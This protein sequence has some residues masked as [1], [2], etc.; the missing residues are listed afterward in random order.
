MG[1]NCSIS[2]FSI[3]HF[4]LPPFKIFACAFFVFSVGLEAQSSL[5]DEARENNIAS[6][7]AVVSVYDAETDSEYEY[8]D[9]ANRHENDDTVAQC[10]DYEP[11]PNR[12]L[13]PLPDFF[14]RRK[15]F[16]FGEF[17]E[18]LRR[19]LKRI[20]IAYNGLA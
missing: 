10:G 15:F 1:R 14:K 6:T 19:K 13:P 9:Q 4:C 5:E 8:E 11:K 16:L 18:D 12:E 17:S 3:F 7:S 20:I 2:L